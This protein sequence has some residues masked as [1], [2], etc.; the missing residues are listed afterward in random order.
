[1]RPL[2]NLTHLRTWDDID[3]DDDVNSDDDD[4]DD[5][6]DDDYDDDDDIHQHPQKPS[7]PAQEYLI[8]ARENQNYR[9]NCLILAWSYYYSYMMIII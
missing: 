5:H 3:D 8:F 7:S 4:D 9:H 6:H 2:S 1:M